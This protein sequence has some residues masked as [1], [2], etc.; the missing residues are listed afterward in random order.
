MARTD[1]SGTEKLPSTGAE[2]TE[3]FCRLSHHS[4]SKVRRDAKIL[5]ASSSL[6]LQKQIM[7]TGGLISL[8][9]R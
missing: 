1:V 7:G 6:S 9:R 2:I 8:K 5:A 4:F 3:M